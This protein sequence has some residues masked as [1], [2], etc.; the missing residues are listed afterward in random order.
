VFCGARSGTELAE[1]YAS[2]DLFPFPSLTETFGNVVT[3]ALASGLA[4]VAF[5][6]AAARQYVHDG[7]NGL[8]APVGDRAA[9]LAGTARL[10]RDP[11]LRARVRASAA[12]VARELTW[13]RAGEQLEAVLLALAHF[14]GVRHD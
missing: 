3:E 5:D 7:V 9:F 2:A 4:V 11:E 12:A 6:Y 14:N 1:H 10:A 13:E 8:L